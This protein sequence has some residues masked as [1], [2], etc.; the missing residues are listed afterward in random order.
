MNKAFGEM[1][2]AIDHGKIEL[3]DD[4]KPTGIIEANSFSPTSHIIILFVITY[5]GYSS[6]NNNY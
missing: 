4:E 1:F 2:L 3:R 6:K 5:G